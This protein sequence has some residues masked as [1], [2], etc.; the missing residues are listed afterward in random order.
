MSRL[1]ST[2]GEDASRSGYGVEDI[3]ISGIEGD[4]PITA[5]TLIDTNGVFESPITS[6]LLELARLKESE[7]MNNVV[8][9][10]DLLFDYE[11]DYYF[12]A[13]FPTVPV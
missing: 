4:L 9:G 1:K 5:S 11:A 3:D 2:K 12:T 7:K 13:A 8:T 6:K 10:S